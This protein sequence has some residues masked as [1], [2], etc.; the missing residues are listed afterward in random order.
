VAGANFVLLA[1]SGRQSM[2]GE[3]TAMV[4]E[5]AVVP[6]LLGSS[7]RLLNRDHFS[8]YYKV[9]TT[10][11]T[12]LCCMPHHVRQEMLS[13]LLDAKLPTYLLAQC[14]RRMYHIGHNQA[15]DVTAGHGEFG[16]DVSAAAAARG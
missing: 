7:Q 6:P 11:F 13:I 14:R 9:L 15:H 10:F 3:R 2:H 12:C 1:A 16:R 5:L 8:V 4:G